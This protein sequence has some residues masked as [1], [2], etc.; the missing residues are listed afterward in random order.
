M[1]ASHLSR[2]AL[3]LTSYGFSCPMC[4][5]FTKQHLP[6]VLACSVDPSTNT[7]WQQAEKPWQCLAVCLEISGALKSLRPE[8]YLSGLPV[9]M[10]GSCNGLQHY[11]ALGRDA[12]GGKAVNLMPS[13]S[14]QDVYKV[15]ACAPGCQAV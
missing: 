10:D 12:S 14:P 9:H 8:T 15:H 6:Q 2:D 5:R 7:W 13:D 1:L 4:R 11:A 3:Q